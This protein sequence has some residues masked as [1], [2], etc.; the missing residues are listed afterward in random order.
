MTPGLQNAHQPVLQ[1]H[2]SPTPVTNVALQSN[3]HMQLVHVYLEFGSTYYY[4]HMLYHYGRIGRCWGAYDTKDY[5]CS[6]PTHSHVSYVVFDAV[7]VAL[8]G[9]CGD[10]ECILE[11]RHGAKVFLVRLIL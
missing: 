2:T 9:G 8:R 7:A 10:G 11:R 3:F 5:E 1:L 4:Q 6:A